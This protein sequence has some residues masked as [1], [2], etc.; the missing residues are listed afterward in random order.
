MADL[1]FFIHDVLSDVPLGQLYPQNYSFNDPAIGNGQIQMQIAI[2]VDPGAV[3]GLKG[4]TTP[5]A[6]AVYVRDGEN[7]LWGGILNYR[8]RTPGIN[9]LSVSGQHWRGWLFD[10][11]VDRLNYYYNP[12][13][14]ATI[15]NHIIS[16]KATIGAGQGG[17]RGHPYFVATAPIFGTQAELTIPAGNTAGAALDDLAGRDN[18]FEWSIAFRSNR[19]TG[20]PEKYLEL[21]KH[22]QTR[23]GRRLLFLDSKQSTNRVAFGMTEES[24]T[25]RRSSIWAIGDGVYPDQPVVNDHDPG[26][27]TNTELLRDE[28]NVRTGV[29]NPTTLFQFARKRRLELSN[30]AQVI[31]VD[32][33]FNEPALTSY[34]S[35]DRVRVR[36]KDN[37]SNIDISGVRI[38]NRTIHKQSTSAPTVT[39]ELDFNDTSDVL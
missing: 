13:D 27:D 25:Q 24:A 18:G 29:I 23:S 6:V 28:W 31:P 4:R 38:T 35:G 12:Q 8:S 36:I 21:W 39:L 17:Y 26:L 1:K 19:T 5:D 22:G 30:T 7:Y 15:A 11:I 10:K 20:L 32:V 34:R 16:M 2:P 9:T 37:W 33:P 3:S 14:M